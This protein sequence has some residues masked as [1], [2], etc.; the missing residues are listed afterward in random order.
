MKI[1][2]SEYFQFRNIQSSRIAFSDEINIICGDNA[3]G[4]TSAIEGIYLCAQGR[5]HRTAKE[6]DFIR[7]GEEIASVSLSYQDKNR[8][9]SLG[10]T[11][12]T[13]GKKGCVRN[14]IPIRK[15]SEFIGHFRAVLFTP[16]HLSIVKEGPAMRRGFLDNAISQLDPTYLLSLQRYVKILQQRNRILAE[17]SFHPEG[18]DTLDVWSMQL[19]EEGELLS[20]K[21]AEYVERADEKLRVIFSDMTEDREVP[22]LKYTGATAKEDLYKL[23][24]GNIDREIRHGSTLYGIHKDDVGIT[25]NRKEARSYA[26]QG[27][28]RSLALA[29]KLAEGEISREDTG[30][31]PVFLFDDVLSELDGRRKQYLMAGLSGKQV[32]ITTCEQTGFPENSHVIHA[33]GGA[34]YE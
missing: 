30:E 15:M 16:E 7:F 29:L 4:K 27:Q 3:V 33:K 19:A 34:F 25:V 2:S 12:S 1:L 14:G 11:F 22:Q 28:Q 26:S 6:R 24:I 32:I 17:A 18:L 31:Y 10:I 20:R 21:R 13:K 5:S 23:L 9:Q 8:V